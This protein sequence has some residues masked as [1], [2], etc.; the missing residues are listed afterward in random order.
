MKVTTKF[1]I[2]GN[3]FT[4]VEYKTLVQPLLELGLQL[5]L[6]LGLGIQGKSLTLVEYKTLVQPLLNKIRLGLGL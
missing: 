6:E 1:G 2:H 5:G 3:S 4:L